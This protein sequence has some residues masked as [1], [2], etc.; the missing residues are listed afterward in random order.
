[1]IVFLAQVRIAD[2]AVL[3][4]EQYLDIGLGRSSAGHLEHQQLQAVE[5]SVWKWPRPHR[6]MMRPLGSRSGGHSHDGPIT[7]PPTENRAL[8]CLR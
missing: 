5:G 4:M 8:P 3:G 1:M 7:R 2:R 6:K